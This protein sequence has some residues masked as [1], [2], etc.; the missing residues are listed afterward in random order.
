M[1]HHADL[2][3]ILWPLPVYEVSGTTAEVLEKTTRPT[4]KAGL[5]SSPKPH[6]DRKLGGEKRQLVQDEIHEKVKEKCCIKMLTCKYTWAELCTSEPLHTKFLIQS[7]Y[8]DPSGAWQTFL[9]ES[10]A[11]GGASWHQNKY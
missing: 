9:S 5:G 6:Y 7:V 2:P 10:C 11:R 1:Y 3:R 4:V 8:D